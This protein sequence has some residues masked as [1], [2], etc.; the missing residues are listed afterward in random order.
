MLLFAAREWFLWLRCVFSTLFVQTWW[1][2][3][4]ECPPE[5]ETDEYTVPMTKRRS[6]QLRCNRGSAQCTT[7]QLDEQLHRC[8]RK[9][10]QFKPIIKV[11]QMTKHNNDRVWAGWGIVSAIAKTYKRMEPFAKWVA[12]SRETLVGQRCVVFWAGMPHCFIGLASL[13]I[14][15]FCQI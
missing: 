9:R 15:F 4:A 1:N 12:I 6:L 10:T 2:N 7:F 5:Y 14:P 3:I 13:S 11:Q 8:E